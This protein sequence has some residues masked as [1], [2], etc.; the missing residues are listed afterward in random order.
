MEAAARIMESMKM[1]AALVFVLG[2]SLLSACAELLPRSDAEV[3]ATW[4]S[5]EEAKAAIDR[6]E[7]NRTTAEE[8]RAA[9]FDPYRNPNV[10]LL[11]YSDI[12]RRFPLG[13]NVPKLDPGLQTCMEAGKA[14]YGYS[15][16][17][18][19]SH[20]ERV[21]PF[22]LD[23]LSFRRETIISGWT[24]NAIVLLVDDHV[25]YSLYGGKPSISEREKNVEPLG[26]LQNWNGA[27]LI[28]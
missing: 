12:L 27:G 9:G 4:T 20:R 3:K 11:N 6:V 28:R 24:F 10:E 14:C 2:S 15:V 26:P 19:N 17:L 18:R 8:L 7:P 25:V 1:F 13:G 21:G 5:F 23:L 16:D 22:L